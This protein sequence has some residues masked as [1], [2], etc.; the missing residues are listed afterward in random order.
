LGT[1]ASVTEEGGGP[2]VSAGPVTLTP[3]L[4]K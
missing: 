3:W 2:T 4:K 1:N